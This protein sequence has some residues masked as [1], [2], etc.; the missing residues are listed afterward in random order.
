MKINMDEIESD[1]EEEQGAHQQHNNSDHNN[2]NT[3]F[4]LQKKSKLNDDEKLE[5]VIAIGTFHIM[6]EAKTAFGEVFEC[7]NVE[8]S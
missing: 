7:D 4:Q 8:V 2:H 6:K 5:F 1:S 3:K